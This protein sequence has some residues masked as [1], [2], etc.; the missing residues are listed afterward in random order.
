MKRLILVLGLVLMLALAAC[1]S[2]QP[3]VQEALP[4]DAAA[5]TVDEAATAPAEAPAD[6]TGETAPPGDRG[7]QVIPELTGQVW[8]WV[9]L[10]TPVETISAVDPAR[11]TIE[12]MADGTA[13]IKADCNQVQA[14][15]VADG[16]GAIVITL[17]P[18]TMAACPED[19]QD[20]LF[21]GALATAANYFSFELD[22]SL[23]IDQFADSGTLRFQPGGAMPAE[24]QGE[25]SSEAATT[26]TGVTW[27]WVSAIDPMGQT[28]A[29]DPTRYT[30]LFNE[31]GSATIK[32]DCNQ[33]VGTYSTDGSN[34]TIELGASTAA[35]CPPDSQE[36]LFRNGLMSA[37]AYTVEDGELFIE[38]QADAGTLMF[39][40]AGTAA[41]EM[42]STTTDAPTLTG[43][44]WQWVS[45][46]TPVE[47]ITVA[48]PTRYTLTFNEDGTVGIQA[49]CN[50]ASGTYTAGDDGS[51]S[52]TMGPSTL[53]VCPPDSQVDAFLAGVASAAIY[54]FEGEDLLID[55]F[56]SA[57]TMRFRAADAA[58]EGGATTESEAMS[59]T[60]TVWLWAGMVTPK[61]A[62]AVADPSRYS[63][64]FMEDGTAAIKADCNQVTATYTTDATGALTITPGASTMALC[65]EDSQD[66]LFVSSLSSAAGYFF[67]EGRLFID[68][69]A[70]AGTLEFMPEPIA[71]PDTDKGDAGGAATGGLV[72]TSWQW[73]MLTTPS[74]TTTVNDPSRY[75]AVFNADGTL[76]LTADCNN[77]NW[78]YTTGDGGMLTITPGMMSAAFCGAG[79]FDQIFL[80]GL[81]NAMSYRLDG[82][83]LVIDMLYE[84]G[85]LAFMPAP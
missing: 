60:G 34:L 30:I 69:V 51:L 23:F 46:T 63:I 43:A 74:G 3:E 21:L 7:E 40:Q 24:G 75:V 29:N 1:N 26:L 62:M 80:G 25:G 33:I 36:Q 85:S 52:I 78:T 47:T 41:G 49:D 70:D 39:R 27:E 73:T 42:P 71:L 35:A 11:Y 81:T 38:L 50:S 20:Q 45:T 55:Q 14:S 56:A 82:D 79:S 65:P 61:A 28:V 6:G 12:F 19:T 58:G 18:S 22:N 8:Q 44:T 31:D 17:G 37:A 15:Y 4:T 32:A 57:G 9:D 5:G 16:S 72:G 77:G 83:N 59:L 76:S 13:S 66:Q 84:S 53:M 64:E 10:T 54:F 68:Q 67:Q 48:D 2:L